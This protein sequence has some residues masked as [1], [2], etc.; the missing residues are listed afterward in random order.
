MAEEEKSI[1]DTRVELIFPTPV[2]CT[3][4]KSDLNLSE[5]KDIENIIEEGMRPNVSNS[6]SQNSYIFDTKLYNLKE[7]CEKHIKTY[8]EELIKPKEEVDFY[9]T[10]S[11]L[12]INKPG[13]SHNKHWH[14]NSIISG[15]FYISTEE[16]DEISF[17][18]PNTKLKEM[19][20]I[21]LNE[22]DLVNSNV[23]ILHV[24]T[25]D[26]L[27][28]PSWLEHSVEPNEK[29]T[30]DRISLGFNIFAKGFFGNKGF[31]SE[32]II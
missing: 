31:L 20:K 6:R 5:I 10:Q 3:H 11:W 15:V 30:T 25:L 16:S 7:F 27:L 12:N 13:E 2:Y 9:I 19:M 32:L 4:K 23:S 17:Y 22:V 1:P 26:L 14:P 21:E 24:N 28:F 8:V 18:D 29:A